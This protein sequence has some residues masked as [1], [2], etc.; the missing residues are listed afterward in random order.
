MMIAV[1]SWN[2]VLTSGGEVDGPQ[3]PR[4][5]HDEDVVWQPGRRDGFERRRQ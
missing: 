2:F 4:L 1:M 3:D 5:I